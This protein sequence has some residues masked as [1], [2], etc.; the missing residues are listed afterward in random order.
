MSAIIKYTP[1]IEKLK[2]L[3]PEL[4]DRESQVSIL[5]F[6]GITIK[7]ISDLLSISER[8]INCH[9]CNSKN[10]FGLSTYQDLK[11]LILLRFLTAH[12]KS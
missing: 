11:T 3:L 2:T 8:T 12:H 5:Y 7:E 1:D 9:I 4:S 6:V 10:K